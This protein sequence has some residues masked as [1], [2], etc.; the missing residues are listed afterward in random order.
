MIDIKMTINGRPFTTDNFHNELEKAVLG[1]ILGHVQNQLQDVPAELN[2][3][4]LMVELLGD[5]LD[6]LSVKLSG[7][8]ELIEQAR[9]AL[10]AE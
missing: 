7:P 3:E 5:D 6:N 9:P 1:Q 2:G 4:K 10:G 8:D